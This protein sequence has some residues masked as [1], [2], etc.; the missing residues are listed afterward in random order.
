MT[1]LL[2]SAG[3]SVNYTAG[4]TISSGDVLVLGT[5]STLIMGVALEDIANGSI[6][7]VAIEGVYNLPKVSAAVIVQGESV[8]WDS[9]ASE[10]DDNQATPA[11]GDISACCVAVE[12]AGNGVTTVAVKLNV[13][14]GTKT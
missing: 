11:S 10:F 12:A 13:G 9:S 1:A 5:N 3:E 7:A 2:D 14:I 6:G 8:I 4:A